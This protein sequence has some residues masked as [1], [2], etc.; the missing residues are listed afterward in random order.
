MGLKALIEGHGMIVNNKPG[1]AT[2]WIRIRSTSIINHTFPTPEIRVLYTW[3]IDRELT[4]TS[5]YEVIVFDHKS[6]EDTVGGMRTS[7]G[8]TGKSVR[9]M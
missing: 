9:G 2:R 3:I 1:E 7:Q 6:L 5:D 4:I 8:V